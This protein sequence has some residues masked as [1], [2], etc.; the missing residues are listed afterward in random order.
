MAGPTEAPLA[1]DRPPEMPRDEWGGDALVRR[2]PH[3]HRQRAPAHRG[4]SAQLLSMRTPARPVAT[5]VPAWM[6]GK[7]PSFKAG[8]ERAD[9]T[10]ILVGL[11]LVRQMLSIF[12]LMRGGIQPDHLQRERCSPATSNRSPLKPPIPARCSGKGRG[13]LRPFSTGGG[14]YQGR[15]GCPSAPSLTHRDVLSRIGLAQSPCRGTLAEATPEPHPSF[16]TQAARPINNHW[17]LRPAVADDFA[18]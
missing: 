2:G 8:K 13:N 14:E 6:R 7:S 4:A 9:A 15:L 11:R 5:P 12:P 1:L 17:A 18:R 3:A 16:W 10:G